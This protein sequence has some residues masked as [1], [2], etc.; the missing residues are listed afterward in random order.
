MTPA[1]YLE[2][3]K[4]PQIFVKFEMAVIGYSRAWGKLIN[5]KKPEGKNLVK[6]SL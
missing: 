5:E 2:L 1:L 4:S 6:L 3:R